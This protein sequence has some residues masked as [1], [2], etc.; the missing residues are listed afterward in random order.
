MT[1]SNIINVIYLIRKK[2]WQFQQFL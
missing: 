1:V 2:I